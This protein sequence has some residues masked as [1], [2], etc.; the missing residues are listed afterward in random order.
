V[1]FVLTLNVE[2]TDTL[3]L[4]AQ[5]YAKIFSIIQSSEH[6]GTYHVGQFNFFAKNSGKLISKYN[7]IVP[8]VIAF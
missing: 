2:F 6:L 7:N 4:F 1:T 5:P 8:K 3:Y